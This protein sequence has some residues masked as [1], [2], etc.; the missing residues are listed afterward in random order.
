M[1]FHFSAIFMLHNNVPLEVKNFWFYC[2]SE[3][4]ALILWYVCASRL[5]T[6]TQNWNAIAFTGLTERRNGSRTDTEVFSVLSWHK[7]ADPLDLHMGGSRWGHAVSLL[8][9]TDAWNV[10]YVP[11]LQ[12]LHHTFM[13]FPPAH[14]CRRKREAPLPGVSYPISLC[15]SPWC[16]SS[17]PFFTLSV[18]IYLTLRLV[19]P[20]NPHFTPLLLLFT[21]GHICTHA[22]AS[23]A[24]L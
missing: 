12:T 13:S 10:S 17:V 6:R 21:C 2:G 18:V 14:S 15:L 7:G 23:F 19:I 9:H 3:T 11:S 4:K 20:H 24:S 5:Q 8:C 1:I 22:H 16:C